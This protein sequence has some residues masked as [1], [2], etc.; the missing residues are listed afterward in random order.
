MPPEA[1]TL[2]HLLQDA[3]LLRLARRIVQHDDLHLVARIR[4]VRVATRR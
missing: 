3:R 1:P 2:D 4:L